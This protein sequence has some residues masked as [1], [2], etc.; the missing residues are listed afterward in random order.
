[1][2]QLQRTLSFKATYAIVVGSVIGSGVF[3]KPAV[4]AGQLGSAWLLILVW[5]VAGLITLFGALSNAEAAAMFPETGGQYVFFQKMY[6][7][8]FA[9]VYGWSAFAVFNTAGNASIAYVCAQYTEYFV[10]LPKFSRELEQSIQLPLPLIGTIYPLE[11]FGV[12]SLTI[13]LV[14]LFTAINYCSVRYGSGLQ[15]ILTAL[16]VLAIVL[17]VLGILFS[18][19]GDWAN[20]QS[21]TATDLNWLTAFMAAMAG[22]FWAYDGWNNITFIAGEVREPQRHIPKSLLFGLLTCISIYVL[23]NL[24]FVYV[25]PL[26]AMT[27]SSFVASDAGKIALGTIGGGLIALLVILSTLG[28]TNA[29]ILSTARVTFALGKASDRLNWVG[30]VQP[31]Y[32]TPGNALW[33]NAGWSILLIFSGS[34]DM[35]TDMLIFVS[36]FFYGMSALG[37]IRLRR[38]MPDVAR[39]YRVWAYPWPTIL[40]VVFTAVFLVATLYTDIRLYQ[41]GKSHLINAAFGM[42]IAGLGIPFYFISRKQR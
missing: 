3:M 16:K 19:K 12:K 10:Q 25:L 15:R 5:I 13:F 38:I 26:S 8:G 21:T 27:Q 32:Q 14:L 41:E 37:I 11:N 35:L 40:F 31:R 4:M 9:F 22:A 28:T 39:P 23:I 2:S 17:V 29:N 30:K 36:W 24:A 20:L 18:G 42:L 7:E 6:G 34:F 33:L 1:M